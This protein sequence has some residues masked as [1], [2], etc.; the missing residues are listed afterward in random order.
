MRS[1]RLLAATLLCGLGVAAALSP[2]RA[3]EEQPSEEQPSD[4]RSEAVLATVIELNPHLNA[5]G[6]AVEV[7]DARAT[8]RGTV[9]TEVERKL[10][11]D[12]ARGVAGVEEVA[13]HLVVRPDAARNVD[14]PALAQTVKDANVEARVAAQLLWNKHT[15]GSDIDVATAYGRVTL[16]GRAA[17]AEA[18]DW[19]RK[20]ARS[21][22]GVSEVIE[23]VAVESGGGK[24]S[25][26]RERLSD[27]R[28]TAR[29]ARTLHFNQILDDSAIDVST[30]N[31]VVTLQGTV[32]SEHQRRVAT[33]LAR[34]VYGVEGLEANLRIRDAV[35]F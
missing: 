33:T 16:T 25:E 35:A 17:S 5:Y 13:N 6:I 14:L 20:I 1:D 26:E 9:E 10:A 12:I 23:D 32:A 27:S 18:V 29:V 19:A 31:G 4:T 30:V 22:R 3:Q 28:I 34:N 24:R 11:G 7:S 2:A 21:T 15:R 8:L